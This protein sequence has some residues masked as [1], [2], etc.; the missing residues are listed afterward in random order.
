MDK[1]GLT[2]YVI[3]VSKRV[4]KFYIHLYY[5]A[6]ERNEILACATTWMKLEDIM[7]SEVR[8]S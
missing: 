3:N 5:S 2:T 4:N 1:Q 7:L 6:S 8:K